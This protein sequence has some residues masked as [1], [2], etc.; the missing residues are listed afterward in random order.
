MADQ[1]L[2]YRQWRDG[3]RWRWQVLRG[4]EVVASGAE[5]T[6]IAARVA[7]FEMCQRQQQLETKD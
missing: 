4:R 7:A 1:E 5:A 2:S 3:S 6:S